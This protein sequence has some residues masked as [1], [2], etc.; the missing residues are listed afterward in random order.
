MENT[1]LKKS[2]Q[3]STHLAMQNGYAMP[4]FQ[5]V[6]SVYIRLRDTAISPEI[7]I[8]DNTIDNGLINFRYSYMG[9]ACGDLTKD[10]LED[11][12]NI[13][14]PILRQLGYNQIVGISGNSWQLEFD[15]R[16]R[17]IGHSVTEIL[18]TISIISAY[19]EQN[20]Y[21]LFETN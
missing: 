8:S 3:V 5:S 20:Y 21:D 12:I 6:G 15:Y 17:N 9:T 4:W 10:I 11:I 7:Y 16:P 18:K 19:F 2:M 13:L 1:N 14:N